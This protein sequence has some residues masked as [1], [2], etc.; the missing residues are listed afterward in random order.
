MKCFA[1]LRDYTYDQLQDAEYDDHI[2]TYGLDERTCFE[3]I[4]DEEGLCWHCS[5]PKGH[6]DYHETVEFLSEKVVARWDDGF[7]M[8]AEL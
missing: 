8:A 7:K 2:N 1:L 5:R 3:E 6:K 4:F